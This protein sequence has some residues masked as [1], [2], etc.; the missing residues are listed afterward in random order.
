MHSSVDIVQIISVESKTTTINK[1]ASTAGQ[2]TS[3]YWQDK[4]RRINLPANKESSAKVGHDL[5]TVKRCR[6]IFGN[7]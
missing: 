3:G 6:K 5:D 2:N 7:I 4:I 1:A